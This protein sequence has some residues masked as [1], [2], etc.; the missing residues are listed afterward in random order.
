MTA[1]CKESNF[2]MPTDQAAWN[3]GPVIATEVIQQGCAGLLS[4]ATGKGRLF[5]WHDQDEVHLFGEPYAACK[6]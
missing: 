5:M 3:V 2:Y 4:F 6:M 1:E